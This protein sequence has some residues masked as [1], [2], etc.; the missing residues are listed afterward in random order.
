MAFKN[1]IQ[2]K[3]KSD[4][5]TLTQVINMLNSLGYTSDKLS[6]DEKAGIILGE[7]IKEMI[8]QFNRDFD[9]KDQSGNLTDFVLSKIIEAGKIIKAQS[10]LKTLNYFKGE[11]NG[12]L[13]EETELA[14]NK[15]KVDNNISK[16]DG[17]LDKETIN[18]LDEKIDVLMSLKGYVPVKIDN[19]EFTNFYYVD[20]DGTLT[21]SR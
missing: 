7:G 10:Q 6:R 5:Y 4:S 3:H 17:K 20:Q 2:F 13:D 12:M 21:V 8:Q 16:I 15:F 14:I 18:L 19:S 1:E 9:I 11:P